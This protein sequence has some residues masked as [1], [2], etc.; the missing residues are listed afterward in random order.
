MSKES[1]LKRVAKTIINNHQKE[2][3]KILIVLPNKRAITFLYKHL[4]EENSSPFFSPEIVTIYDWAKEVS[5]RRIASSTELLF[6]MYETHKIVEGSNAEDINDF[7][8]WGGMLVSD[9]DEIERYKI[10]PEEIFSDLKNIKELE[11]WNIGEDEMSDRQSEFRKFWLKLNQYYTAYNAQ[12]E[13]ENVENSAKSF[14][15]L[16][17]N[18]RNDQVSWK[19]IYFIG[20]N[21]LSRVEEDLI[22][23]LKRDK[24][25][26]VIFDMD[27]FYLDIHDHEAKHFY[28]EYKDNHNLAE[29]YPNN[30]EA[31]SKNFRLIS[32]DHSVQQVGA[33]SQILSE[34]NPSES[35]ALVLAD[36][37]LTLPIIRTLPN[38]FTTVNVTLGFPFFHTTFGSLFEQ[39]FEIQFSFQKFGSSK[40]YFKTL[41][42]LIDQSW[43]GAFVSKEE[44]AKYENEIIRQ[45][46]VFISFEDL[47]IKFPVLEQLSILFKP[48]KDVCNDGVQALKALHSA[49]G[50]EELG[51]MEGEV[52]RL[53][54]LTLREADDFI[55]KYGKGLSLKTLK[56]IL[57]EFF[58]SQDLSFY[59]NPIN[60]LQ[61]MGILET[62]TLDFD[63]LVVV[64]LNE[65]NLPKT[66]IAKTYIP[67]DLRKHHGLPCE[68]DRQAIF[69]HHFYRLLQRAKKVDL[70]FEDSN[71]GF[72]ANEPSRYINQLINDLDF[73][74]QHTLKR[75]NVGAEKTNDISSSEF[76]QTKLSF[77]RIKDLLSNKGLSPTA[78]NNY[79][80]CSKDFYYRSVLGLRDEDDVEE[81]IDHSSFGVQIHAVLERIMKESFLEKNKNLNKKDLKNLKSELEDML[82]EAYAESKYSSESLQTGKNKLAFEVSLKLLEKFMD[83]QIKEVEN[84][85]V[86]IVDLEKELSAVIPIDYH[87]GRIDVKIYG[88]VD[89]IDKVD[90]VYRIIDYKSGKS[91]DEK[92]QIFG[93]TKKIS[94]AEQMT[95]FFTDEHKG[96]GRQLA[97][98]SIMFAQN[99][100]EIKSFK[101]GIIALV[102]A[103]NWLQSIQNPISQTDLITSDLL[104]LFKE[105]LAAL[106]KEILS[107]E[108]VFAHNKSAKYCEFC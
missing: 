91:S 59:G 7:L 49:L 34:K 92:I 64:G 12:L 100:P 63:E 104:D 14:L 56:K 83:Q 80:T 11:H 101:S 98:Y 71:S 37:S 5:N 18:V 22:F 102:N 35:I 96:H 97:L 68:E 94:I 33:V 90:G 41:L 24:K 89:R 60:G 78:L 66:N 79:V 58:K 9:F 50:K 48:W 61:V 86:E 87:E 47:I 44:L 21:A 67:R 108:K 81:E 95:K 15:N 23:S 54:D 3:D 25:A 30:F 1:F 39:V 69:A 93:K 65:G 82:L 13:Q 8:K 31:I 38:K 17:E 26:T 103:D 75:L 72:G 40:L 55:A 29:Q 27:A 73:E 51:E 32:A 43:M 4:A 105:E 19:H 6:L 16:E 106:L 36:E 85:E 28:A 57:S 62:R 45:N 99:Y 77:E 88:L 2:L 53:F 42:A 70:I 84:S 10:D 46:H 52:Y 107:S 20:F 76:T 74:N